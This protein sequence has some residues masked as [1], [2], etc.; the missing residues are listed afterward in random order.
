MHLVYVYRG[1]YGLY[2]GVYLAAGVLHAQRERVGYVLHHL[3]E[4][5]LLLLEHGLLAVE[6]RHLEHF[7]H[8]ET[9]PFGL[10]VYHGAQVLHH[11]GALGHALVVEHLRR[12]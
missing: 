5:E 6:H 4:V 10:V 11:G 7:L 1:V 2:L 12:Q 9:Q 3:V 8:E